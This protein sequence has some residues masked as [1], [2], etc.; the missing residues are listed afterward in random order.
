MF[1]GWTG[2]EEVLDLLLEKGSDSEVVCQRGAT[3]L[4]HAAEA[5]RPNV[6]AR[7]LQRAGEPLVRVQ[8][9]VGW[10]ALHYAAMHECCDC[11]A[12]LIQVC[13]TP[14]ISRPANAGICGFL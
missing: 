7:L 10:T 11:A 4:H 5:N 2:S 3:V 14:A 8:D 6:L 1:V 9:S 12:L 13:P